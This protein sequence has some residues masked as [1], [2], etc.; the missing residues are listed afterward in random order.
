[1]KRK[2][3][4]CIAI[5]SLAL[6]F[7]VSA[8]MVSFLIVEAGLNDEAPGTQLGAIWEDGLMSSFFDAGHIVTNN[9]ILRLE[10]RPESA[11]FG[12]VRHDFNDATTGGAEF[13]ILCIIDYRLEDRRIVPVSITIKAYRVG[14]QELVSEQS[15]P[16]GLGRTRIEEIRNAQD[17][18]R[19]IISQLRGL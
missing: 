19:I 10:E 12:S 18:G 4:F 15:F 2:S 9:P 6:I 16:V 13:F 3:L 17:A 5:L 11:L 7:P 1:M 8:S 14:T